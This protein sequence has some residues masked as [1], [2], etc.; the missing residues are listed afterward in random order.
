MLAWLRTFYFTTVYNN[1][2]DKGLVLNEEKITSVERKYMK[3]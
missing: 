3:G 1:S 2:S